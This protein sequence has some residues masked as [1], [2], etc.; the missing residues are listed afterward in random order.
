MNDDFYFWCFVLWLG[1]ILGWGW[2]LTVK[3][4]NVRNWLGGA[5]VIFSFIMSIILCPLLPMLSATY[6]SVKNSHSISMEQ[7]FMSIMFLIVLFAP[8]FIMGAALKRSGR[9]QTDKDDEPPSAQ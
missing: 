7:G 9:C 5:V 1:A 4:K 3:S 2:M 8:M 6:R